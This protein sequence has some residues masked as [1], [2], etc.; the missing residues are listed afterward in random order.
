[1]DVSA[2]G[3]KAQIEADLGLLAQ[4]RATLDAAILRNPSAAALCFQRVSVLD[5][6][7]DIEAAAR[8]CARALQ[9]EPDDPVALSE[10]VFL[11]KRTGD[12]QDLARLQ[13]RFRSGVAQGK[14]YLAPFSFLSDPSTRA[15]QRRCAERWSALFAPHGD[16][17]QQGT[18]G[19][20]PPTTQ[21]ATQSA[22]QHVAQPLPQHA[23]PLQPQHSGRTPPSIRPPLRPRACAS[24]I[25]RRISTSTRPPSSPPACSKR[26]TAPSSK[27]SRTRRV[28][29]TRQRSRSVCEPRS[30]ISSTC[31]AGRRIASP[32]T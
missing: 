9:L 30:S 21:H 16:A 24:A 27:S 11:R 1:M 7:G 25:C 3:I 29:T 22:A 19:A 28:P 26:T 4:A 23:T 15:E 20:A 10:L 12:W 8:S 6:L 2:A 18:T 14:P 5:A 32:R 31:G 13:Q 17:A